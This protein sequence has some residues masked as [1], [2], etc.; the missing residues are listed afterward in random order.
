M[1][2]T[3][4]ITLLLLS[5]N[6]FAQRAQRPQGQERQPIKIT[7]TVLDKDN[8]DP[9]EYATLVLQSVDNPEKV[10]GGIT[11][12]DGKF[13]VETLPGKYNIS[14][15]YIS[16]K[17]YKLPNQL[18][19]ES[20]DLGTVKLALDVAQLEGVEVVGEKTTVEVRLDKKI[21]NIGKD[22]TTSGATISDALNNVPSVNVDVEGAISLRGNENVRIL[23][24]GKPSALAGFGSTDALR[25]LPAD[26]IEKVEVIT[27][28]SARYDAEGTAGILNIVLKREKTLGFNGSVSV[29]IGYPS[30]SSMSVNAN[31]RT[32]KFNVFNTLGYRYNESPGHAFY[33]NSYNDGQYDQINENRDY[34]RS[35]KGFNNNFGVEYFFNEKSSLTG[36]FFMRFQD[37]DDLTENYSDYFESGLLTRKSFREEIELEDEENYQFSLNYVNN[38]DDDGQ[39]L[40][41]DLQYSNGDEVENSTID[42]NNTF[43]NTSLNTL[44]SIYQ[45]EIDDEYLV[46]ADYVLPMGDAQFEV[47][48]RGTFEREITDY[49]LDSLNRSTNQFVTNED[50]TNKFTYQENVN[51][52]YT[53]YGNKFGKFSF[54]AGLRLE[55]TQLKGEVTSDFDTSAIEDALGE[56]VDLNFDKNYLGLFPTLNLIFEIGEMENISLGYNRRINRPRGR[57]INPFPSRASRANIF[58]GNPDLDPAYSNS[59]DLGYLKR[60]DK[61]T[62]TSSVYYKRET[63][64]FEYIQEATGQTTTD[65][66][67]IIRS[68][69][70]NLSSNERIGA[71]AGVLYNPKK[72][73]RLN[74]SVNFFQFSS[75]GEHNGTD[76]GTDNT[77]WFAR[78]S[79]KV[80]LPEKIEWQTNAFYMG[81]R[82]NS[83]T[84]TKGMLSL[85]L[86]FSKDIMKDKGTVS[87]NVSDL[88]NSRKRQSYTV[89]DDFTSRSEFQFRPRSINLSFR[90]R[91]NQSKDRDRKNGR[92]GNENGGGEDE[93]EG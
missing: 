34:T 16:Y 30:Q 85:N 74:G 91:I 22:L 19:N 38:I 75:E 45:N 41:A 14:V 54:L 35:G 81:P 79:S 50:L 84:E 66:V 60:W 24:N 58:Q 82:Q 56:D 11:D 49:K 69:P 25:E 2:K 47:G 4:L 8:G 48:Y 87:L 13:S 10:T 44:E 12:I 57:F 5:I 73:L 9:L 55:N 17:T 3:F 53:Q 63:N 29:N 28:P 70:I 80:S 1:R 90:Y 43:P 68:L 18:L 93:M 72:W 51:A 33:E 23:I 67:R 64:S 20:T 71:E 92:G 61:L 26:A 62:L 86:A 52:L 65:S 78:F 46:Q 7:G 77:S 40:T 83:Q 37:G 21:Y 27:S 59:F 6:A 76:Y 36:S 15:E 32:N 88:L 31:L 89:S 42:D 39:K